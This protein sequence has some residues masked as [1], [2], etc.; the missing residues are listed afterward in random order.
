MRRFGLLFALIAPA[1]GDSAGAPIDGN[2]DPGDTA[3]PTPDAEPSDAPDGT[4]PPDATFVPPDAPDDDSGIDY[5]PDLIVV[6]SQMTDPPSIQ[7]RNFGPDDPSVAEG[8]V[9]GPGQRRILKFDTVSGNTG[10]LDVYAGVPGP[11]NPAFTWSPAHGH[12]H[13]A[14]FAE[15]RLE[16]AGGTVVTGHKQAFCLM[17]SLQITGDAGPAKYDCDNQGISA[18]W[19]DVYGRYLDCQ[20]IDITNVAA[21]DYTLAIE[22]NPQQIF[23]ESDLTNNVWTTAVTIPPP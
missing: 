3:P 1:C 10:N 21:G 15:Y 14:G 22:I 12:Y 17:D 6:G 18:G 4:V 16:N 5:L 11:D 20:W 7:L 23:D 19:S 8:C 13:V 2:N 9:V